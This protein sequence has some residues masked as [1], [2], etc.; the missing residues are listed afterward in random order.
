MVQF[1]K[2]IQTQLKIFSFIHFKAMIH[3]VT[4]IKQHKIPVLN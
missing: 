3:R 2:C 4:A 1:H